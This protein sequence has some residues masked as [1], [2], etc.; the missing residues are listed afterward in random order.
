MAVSAATRAWVLELLA[1]L[2]GLSARAMMGGLAIYSEGRIFALLDSRDRLYL[3]ATGA[4]AE[5]LAAEGSQ[6]FAYERAGSGTTRMGYWTLRT[7]RSTTPRL[8]ATGRARRFRR[9]IPTFPDPAHLLAPADTSQ[10]KGGTAWPFAS[11][12]PETGR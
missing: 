8:P 6:Q 1:G 3:K 10:D 5:R 4:F 2:P 9:A 11:S 12:S 7:P